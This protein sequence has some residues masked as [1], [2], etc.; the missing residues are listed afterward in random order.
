LELT[1]KTNWSGI[2]ARD[3][4]SIEAPNLDMV[5][6]VHSTFASAKMI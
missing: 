6:I 5:R 3:D 1:S 2:L 4:A